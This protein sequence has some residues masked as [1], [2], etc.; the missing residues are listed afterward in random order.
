MP[1][2]MSFFGYT[3]Q[4]PPP[5]YH[6]FFF[7]TPSPPPHSE[8]PLEASPP[9][10]FSVSTNRKG[11]D[12][13]GIFFVISYVLSFRTKKGAPFYFISLPGTSISSS[14]KWKLGY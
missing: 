4:F 13:D 7:V 5:L 3:A 10:P 1:N 14:V 11:E 6:Y 8:D 9:P 12:I 2:T